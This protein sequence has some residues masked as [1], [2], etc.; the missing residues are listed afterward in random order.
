GPKSHGAGGGSQPIRQTG[1]L[2]HISGNPVFKAMTMPP[3]L[4]SEKATLQNLEVVKVDLKENF[5]LVK[6][7]V[8]GAK[9]FF[10]VVKSGVKGVP[11]KA[12]VKLVDVKEVVLMN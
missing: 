3:H 5:L 8:P 11:A 9:N 4:G 7:S 12:G 1:S 10:V 6:G 2:G